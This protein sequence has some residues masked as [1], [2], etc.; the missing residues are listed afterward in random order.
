[1]A[2]TFEQVFAADPANPANVAQ[3]AA[4]TIYAPGDA[5]KAPLTITDPSG[6]ALS[7]PLTVNAN[8]FGSA[9]MHATLDRVAWDGGGFS[10]FFTSYDG[11]KNVAVAAQAAAEDAAATAGA[12]AAAVA[13]A[14]IGDATADADAAAASA[15]TAATNAAAS[16][17]AAA[18]SASLVGAPAD[19][20]VETLINAPGSATR[21]A[22]KTTVAGEVT[23]TSSATRTALNSTYA[24]KSIEAT[25]AAKLDKSAK[26]RTPTLRGDSIF[27]GGGSAYG[28]RTLTT[29]TG[30]ARTVHVAGWDGSN[31]RVAYGNW[32]VLTGGTEAAG[33][34]TYTVKASL[35]YGSVNYP[36]TFNGAPTALVGPGGIAQTDP[37]GLDIPAAATFEILTYMTSDTANWQPNHASL[38][39]T[40]TGGFVASTD[41]TAVGAAAVPDS[42]NYMYGPYAITATPR[43]LTNVRGFIAIGDSIMVGQGEG[44]G[45]DKGPR[46][47]RCAINRATNGK[48]GVVIVAREGERFSHWTV[49]ANRLRRFT[50]VEGITDVFCN[51]GRNDVTNASSLATL[52]ADAIKVWNEGLFRGAR[53]H[54]TTITPRTTS[55]DAWATTTNQTVQVPAEETVRVNFNT[56]LRAGA[57]IVAGV[58]VA[59][60]TSGALLVGQAGHPLTSVIDVTAEVESALNSGIWKAAYTAD[61]LHPTPVGYAAMY[62]IYPITALMAETV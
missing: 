56:W 49:N 18:N 41:S 8:G 16:A 58:A 62:A 51:L 48:A 35:R 60:G 53:V 23:D 42:I 38:N 52:Q 26:P 7:N 34:S 46:G 30:T 1:M 45:V 55:T 29:A 17:T 33:L 22:L 43:K 15:A 13:T 14:A 36:L 12:D 5:T 44:S 11:I 31:I 25:V 6:G 47:P 57:P 39:T 54:Q 4:I 40:G 21:A 19:T 3:N 27:A 28:D 37:L 59:I 9:F 61:G 10:G 24:G 2:F 50:L 20:A 32:S